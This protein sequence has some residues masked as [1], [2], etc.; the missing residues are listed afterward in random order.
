VSKIDTPILLKESKKMYHIIR[1]DL[2]IPE[3]AF[4]TGKH[5]PLRIALT[6]ADV[7]VPVFVHV[8]PGGDKDA[9]ANA[10][11]VRASVSNFV[12]S[13]LRPSGRTVRTRIVQVTNLDDETRARVCEAVGTEVSDEDVTLRLTKVIL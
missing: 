3:E 1:T 6:N 13:R 11:T 2:S 8:K 7:D 12:E 5:R 9:I 10:N 4:D